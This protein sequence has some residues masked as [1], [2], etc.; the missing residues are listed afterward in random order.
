[1][2]RCT[3]ALAFLLLITISA[4]AAEPSHA[5]EAMLTLPFETVLPG[6]PFDMTVT[7]KNVS[8]APV[9]VGVSAK[10]VVTMPD[11]TD[12]SP[13]SWQTMLEPNPFPMGQNWVELAPGESRVCYIEWHHSL[14]NFFHN[15]DFAGPGVYGLTFHLGGS[16]H[17]DN[18]VGEVVTNTAHITRAVPPPG[19][20]EVLWRKMIAA[21]GG[22][23]APD[24]FCDPKTGGPLLQEILQVHPASAYYPYA[25]L[26]DA[27]C[28]YRRPKTKDDIPKALE[29][30]QRFQS[31][32][33]HGHL[34]LRAAEVAESIAQHA[35]WD[36][37]DKM[38]TEYFGIAAQYY[39]TAAKAAKVP[40]VRVT[41]EAGK[42]RV[43]ASLEHR[44]QRAAGIGVYAKPNQ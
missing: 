36:H 37:D 27:E 42:Q 35:F 23:W 6:V 28:N 3:T 10:L 40:G 41:A 8:S 25:L 18:Y 22:R 19:E 15:P 12:L 30:A 16:N 21:T 33:A 17:P 26:I 5:I 1:M 39:D 13:K 2:K 38:L 24:S 31:S 7:L 44:R 29:A 4:L 43:E 14:D 11:G 9:T 34:L 20:D 32:P